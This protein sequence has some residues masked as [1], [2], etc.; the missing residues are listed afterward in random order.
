[1]NQTRIPIL[2]FK[3]PDFRYSHQMDSVSPIF[4]ISHFHNLKTK[5]QDFFNINF[6]NRAG[7][8]TNCIIKRKSN[9]P[10]RESNSCFSVRC[11]ANEHSITAGKSLN[12]PADCQILC[13]TQ[14]SFNPKFQGPGPFILG[15]TVIFG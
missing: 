13:G 9:E 5:D 11:Q 8:Y 15:K 2:A 10:D 1:M 6:R 3:S 4:P 7:L 14:G 12:H